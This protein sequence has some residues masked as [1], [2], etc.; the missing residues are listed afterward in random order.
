MFSLGISSSTV[1]FVTHGVTSIEDACKYAEK[2]NLVLLKG[3]NIIN[4]Y[5]N[6]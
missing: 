3:E 6:I 5:L 2:N 1:N 4:A